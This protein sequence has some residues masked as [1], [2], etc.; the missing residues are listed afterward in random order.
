MQPIALAW[1]PLVTCTFVNFFWEGD[2]Y[3]EEHVAA[4]VARFYGGQLEADGFCEV[5]VV[6]AAVRSLDRLV[7]VGYHFA[8]SCELG[9]GEFRVG[10]F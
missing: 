2:M 6:V 1:V 5:D 9:G 8:V 7:I 10:S 3:E 4:Q